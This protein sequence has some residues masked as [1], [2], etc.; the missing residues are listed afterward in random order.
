[1]IA[2]PEEKYAR[3]AALV[4][5]VEPHRN[6]EKREAWRQ[7]VGIV[8]DEDVAS[9]V[10]EVAESDS[11]GGGDTTDDGL[12]SLTVAEL[13]AYAAE[14]EIELGE[15]KKKVDIIATIEASVS[16]D[17]PKDDDEETDED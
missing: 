16:E 4:N 3:I 10:D 9:R 15:A 1:M 13:K 17:G 5:E 6:A 8:K 11:D 14:H 12:A 7:I 2:S